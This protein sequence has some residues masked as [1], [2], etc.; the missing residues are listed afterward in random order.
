MEQPEVTTTGGRVRG[1][2]R[3]FGAGP[4]DSASGTGYRS[5][6]FLGIPY[7]EPPVGTLRF[8]APQR[9]RRWDGVRNAVTQG[10]TPQRGDHGLT[11]IPEPSVP[12]TS[13]LNVNVFTPD[14]SPSAALPV[15]VWIHGGGY[16]AGSPASPWYDGHA[17]NRDGVVV[18]SLSYRLGFEGFGWV[19]DSPGAGVAN[20]RAIRDWLLAL[21]W[22]Q[23]N[24][25][26]FGGDP[27]RVTLA[28]QSAGGGAVLTLLGMPA[29]QALFSGVWASS[30]AQSI[31]T[32][33]KAGETSARL[34]RLAGTEPTAP[35]LG[36]LPESRVRELQRKAARGKKGPLT[37]IRSLVGGGLS[38]AP[39]L[40]GDLLTGT[41]K[42]SA[43]T[44]T[45]GGK[46]LVLGC[47]DDEFSLLPER[48]ARLLE[49]V[50]AGLA[51][52]ALGLRGSVR[53]YV[54]ANTA[55][56]GGSGTARLLGRFVT[57]NVFR[58]PALDLAEH[59][60]G[61]APTWL[62]RFA[63]ESPVRKLS[64]HCLD[65]PFFFD[66]LDGGFPK[67]AGRPA[68]ESLLGEKPPQALADALHGDAVSF[69]TTG[70]VEWAPFQAPGRATARCY[71][72]PL[73]EDTD[74]YASVRP[75]L[76]T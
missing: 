63:W 26:A 69:A 59:R 32:L 38:F 49:R 68:I 54:G 44:G 18:V 12:G 36:S 17:F 67:T 70:K 46:P 5:A 56:P 75:L 6:A 16:L 76:H 34:A 72:L 25:R 35:G 47:T 57:D 10:P 53:D 58:A 55:L 3:V 30:P 45:G 19:E 13:T 74:A 22:V 31:V 33:E 71:D 20:N 14:P 21:E 4:E 66:C 62:Y 24:I 50:P 8:A 41:P 39:V 73:A 61:T 52:R 27:S 11:S 43:E 1:V 2:W 48:L 7:A 37:F 15:L 64:V 40:D 42:Q 23:E 29:A 60:I 9:H 51:L 65:V 28:G